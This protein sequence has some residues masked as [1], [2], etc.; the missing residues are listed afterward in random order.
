MNLLSYFAVFNNYLQMSVFVFFCFPWS[1]D[2]ML[3]IFFAYSG[4]VRECLSI[5]FYSFILLNISTVFL[6]LLYCILWYCGSKSGLYMVHGNINS[7][8]H[9]QSRSYAKHFA[10]Y[11]FYKVCCFVHWITTFPKNLKVKIR[12]KL[13]FLIYFCFL[14]DFFLSTH[15][16]FF[17]IYDNLQKWIL[18][19]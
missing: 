6:I 16:L 7:E 9:P 3:S 15:L 19:N 12:K 18:N 10:L 2:I 11:S 13:S 8:P 5:I 1:A 17:K 4:F 14:Q